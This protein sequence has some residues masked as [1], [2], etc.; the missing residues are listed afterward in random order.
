VTALA[1]ARGSTACRTV[2]ELLLWLLVAVAIV[3]VAGLVAMALAPRFGPWEAVIVAGGSM[4]PTLGVGSIAVMERVDGSM[5]RAN[6]VVKFREPESNRVVTHRVVAVLP[7]GQLTMRGDAN[8]VDDPVP[9]PRGAVEA[10]LLFV[11]PFVGQALRWLGSPG[12][13]VTVVLIPGLAVIGWEVATILRALR[14]PPVES[15]PS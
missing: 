13:Y 4:E 7:D 1:I 11:V 10:R 15:R 6:D 9:V 3:V 14:R 2:R 8:A 5:V 12:G